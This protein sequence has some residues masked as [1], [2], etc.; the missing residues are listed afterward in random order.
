MN[1][2]D[3]QVEILNNLA[4]LLYYDASNYNTAHLEYKFNTNENWYSASY[5]YTK[6]GKNFGSPNFSKN[7]DTIKEL[8]KLLH[9]AM[10]EHSGGDWQKFVL[11]IDENREVQTEFSYEPQSLYDD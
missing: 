5:W 9:D 7:I 8:C 3:Q 2:I 1:S 4:S 10:Q 6:D 11:T